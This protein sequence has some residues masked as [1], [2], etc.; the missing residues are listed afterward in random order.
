MKKFVATLLISIISLQTFAQSINVDEGAYVM[1]YIIESN[2]F[3][4]FGELVGHKDDFEYNNF[5]EVRIDEKYFNT[6]SIGEP[7]NWKKIERTDYSFNGQEI[8]TQMIRE[9]R[10][11]DEEEWVNDLK[12]I[13]T[14]ETEKSI[15][16]HFSWADSSWQQGAR[17][18]DAW[19]SSTYESSLLW[20]TWDENSNDWKKANRWDTIFTADNMFDTIKYFIWF[21]PDEMDTGYI[22]AF[23]YTYY[24]DTIISYFNHH[25]KYDVIREYH[26]SA[27]SANIEYTERYVDSTDSFRPL[28]KKFLYLNSLQQIVRDD[29]YSWHI[30]DEEWDL[31]QRIDFHYNDNNLLEEELLYGPGSTTT[32]FEKRTYSYNPELLLSNQMVYLYP[33]YEDEYDKFDYYYTYKYVDV[34]EESIGQQTKAYPN[35]TRDLLH[36]DNSNLDYHHYQIFNINGKLLRSGKMTQEKELIDISALPTGN[37]VLVLQGEFDSYS[38]QIVKLQ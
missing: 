32:V 12:T 3:H 6:N 25:D 5:N 27:L 9:E 38:Q 18:T 14:Y 28:E 16:T 15:K 22:K 37:Y 35:P 21:S 13:Y 30:Y 1:D 34:P 36:I 11:L 31:L 10:A 7:I 29:H 4:W 2:A 17:W 23:D 26:V 19:N 33:I 24:P 8:L 20:E